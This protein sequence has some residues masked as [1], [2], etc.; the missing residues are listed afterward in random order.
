MNTF[1]LVRCDPVIKSP[2]PRMGSNK[3]QEAIIYNNRAFKYAKEKIHLTVLCYLSVENS[4][5]KH[6]TRLVL[7]QMTLLVG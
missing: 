7:H 4:D 6:K 1:A 2:G 3:C 5:L